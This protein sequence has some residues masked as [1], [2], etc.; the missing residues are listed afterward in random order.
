MLDCGEENPPVPNPSDASL[1]NRPF[2]KPPFC[3]P[4]EPPVLPVLQAPVLQASGT[5]GRQLD[6]QLEEPP[7]NYSPSLP[8]TEHVTTTAFRS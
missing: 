5:T 3:K 4:L 2:C 8:K 7:R 6:A 1:W